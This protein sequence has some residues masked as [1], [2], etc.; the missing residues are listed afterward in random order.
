MFLVGRINIVKMITLPKATY[1]F[2]TITIKLPMVF[3][4]EAQN[5]K[6]STC[7]AGDQG[8]IPGSGR[9]SG[10]GNGKPLQYSCLKN[11][12]DRLQSV[13]LQTVRHN[14]VTNTHRKKKKFTICMETQKTL[15]SQNNLEKEKQL[16]VSTFLTSDDTTKI[17]SSRQHGTGI[18]TEI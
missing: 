1:R 2:S 3:P 4:P 13:G 11:P 16:E 12:M 18:K 6:E 10:E 9:S 14:W 17:Q 7:N 15:N 8:S 5:S